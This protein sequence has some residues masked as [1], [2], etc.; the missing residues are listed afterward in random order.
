MPECCYKLSHEEVKTLKTCTLPNN[1][2]CC[3]QLLVIKRFKENI[4]IKTIVTNKLYTINTYLINK[5]F[6]LC[7]CWLLYICLLLME[8][9]VKV[10]W[11]RDRRQRASHSMN[12]PNSA[13]EVWSPGTQCGPLQKQPRYYVTQQGSLEVVLHE[14]AHELGAHD[15]DPGTLTCRG[16]CLN[17]TET[18]KGRWPL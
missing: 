11:R 5:R 8:M 4:Y 17:A 7:A 1:C 10:V 14:V 15:V 6:Y 18:R 16:F 2:F 12:K 13:K 9:V 3:T